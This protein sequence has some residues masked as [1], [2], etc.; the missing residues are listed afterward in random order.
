M[1]MKVGTTNETARVVENIN[2][3]GKIE[4][5]ACTATDQVPVL[6][7]DN[8][9]KIEKVEKVNEVKVE[10]KI[11]KVELDLDDS[12][13]DRE[14]TDK[15]SKS[16]A[17]EK[18]LRLPLTSIRCGGFEPK[19]PREEFEG[20]KEEPEL[21][22]TEHLGEIP[23]A[24]NKT[25][26]MKEHNLETAQGVNDSKTSRTIPYKVNNAGGSE[27][28][29][30]VMVTVPYK[31]PVRISKDEVPGEVPVPLDCHQALPYQLREVPQPVP[32]GV[33]LEGEMSSGAHRITS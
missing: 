20:R 28:P 10:V 24:V 27:E 5:C 4:K 15:T 2:F 3:L 25:A 14:D 1:T 33:A 12:V 8:L 18:P 7:L 29:Q 6:V 26:L 16:S 30:R 21:V 31:M 9:K 22:E 19:M 32:R 17:R 11:F 13:A 23:V